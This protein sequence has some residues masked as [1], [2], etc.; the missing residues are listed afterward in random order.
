MNRIFT[1]WSY[2]LYLLKAKGAHALHSPFVFSFYNEV[3]AH[4]YRFFPLEQLESLRPGLLEDKDVLRFQDAG[5]RG[6]WIEKKAGDLARRSLMPPEKAALLF[7]LVHWKKP[8]LILELGTSFG[9][10]T[11]CLAK[12]HISKV[13][14]MEAIPGIAQKA[15]AF[16]E[17]ANVRNIELLVGKVEDLLESWLSKP[18]NQPDLV[19]V[20]ANHTYAATIRNFDLLAKH[21]PDHATIVFDD[22]YWSPEMARAWTEIRRH[23]RVT[24]SLDL[25]GL[26][27]VFFR[28]ES[29]KENYVLRW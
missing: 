1:L 22:V 25:F 13:Y 9:L 16:W 20:D 5:A 7:R 8:S 21:L 12:A 28:K 3:I 18:G 14:T 4:P 15:L 2:L 11:A 27:I 17:K 19:V 24:L 6:G 26:G 10:T 29:K 23:P